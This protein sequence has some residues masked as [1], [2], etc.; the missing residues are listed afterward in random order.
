MSIIEGQLA[1]ALREADTS[2]RNAANMCLEELSHSR[3]ECGR[4]NLPDISTKRNLQQS[5]KKALACDVDGSRQGL[6]PKFGKNSL[7]RR[8]ARVIHLLTIWRGR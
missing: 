8:D 2:S 7:S 1:K 5:Y 4:S 3:R 6:H